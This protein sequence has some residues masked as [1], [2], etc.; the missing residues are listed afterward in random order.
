MEK[1]LKK[2]TKQIISRK[3]A[4]E[5]F[6]HITNGQEDGNYPASRSSILV[7]SL[8]QGAQQPYL[9]KSGQKLD[10]TTTECTEKKN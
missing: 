4:P 2:S 7:G 5:D 3:P 6:G 1:Q 10:M 8:V 9:E